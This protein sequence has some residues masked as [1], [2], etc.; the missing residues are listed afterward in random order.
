MG[1]DF[2]P[3]GRWLVLGSDQ[4]YTLYDTKDWRART[5]GAVRLV[6]EY[7]GWAGFSPDGRW[8]A[9]LTGSRTIELR[10]TVKFEPVIQLELTRGPGREEQAWSPDS[11]RLGI[12]SHGQMIYDWNLV[13]LERELAAMGLGTTLGK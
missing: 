2:S 9:L 13:A 10:D 6:D 11:T 3:D 1:G 12:A 5:L 8:L 7:K 4:G